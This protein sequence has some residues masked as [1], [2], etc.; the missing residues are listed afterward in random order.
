MTSVDRQNYIAIDLELR[1]FGPNDSFGY[2][3][4]TGAELMAWRDAFTSLEWD[5]NREVLW[6]IEP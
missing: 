6:I 1:E 4:V 2:C 5:L 3:V